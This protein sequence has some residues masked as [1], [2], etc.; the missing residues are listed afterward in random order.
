MLPE[1]TLRIET[2]DDEPG[3]WRFTLERSD[4]LGRLDASDVEPDVRGERLALLTLVRGLEA[5]DQPS[6]VALTAASRYLRHGVETEMLEWQAA[7][8][9]WES[10]GRMVPVKHADLWQ[11]VVRASEFHELRVGPSPRSRDRRYR[12]DGR[13]GGVASRSVL[14]RIA[15]LASFGG[16]KRMESSRIADR[17]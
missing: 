7:G 4:G 12:V 16:A 3:A 11:R 8:W 6:R 15:S 14:R 2:D 10:Y 17:T 13:H 9:V 5:L 1:F